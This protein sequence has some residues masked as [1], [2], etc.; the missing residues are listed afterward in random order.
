MHVFF[1][2][3]LALVCSS[4]TILNPDAC[5]VIGKALELD[6]V[7]ETEF[8]YLRSAL[9]NLSVRLNLMHLLAGSVNN[10]KVKF[11]GYIATIFAED[12]RWFIYPSG[13]CV[14]PLTACRGAVVQKKPVAQVLLLLLRW[15]TC[16]VCGSLIR[17][18]YRLLIFL[19]LCRTCVLSSSDESTE[20]TR[21]V[22]LRQGCFY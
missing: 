14:V 1:H 22:V 20:G 12:E 8:T 9:D 7:S 5:D 19:S 16:H 2:P 3:K 10:L 17:A 21:V 4:C 18:S 6:P 15:C 13:T 11:I